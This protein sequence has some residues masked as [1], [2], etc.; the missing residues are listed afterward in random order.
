M[1]AFSVATPFRAAA[2]N[3]DAQTPVMTRKLLL[4]IS[5][6]SAESAAAAERGGANRIELCAD[7]KVGGLTPS[8]ALLR[9]V[10]EKVHLPIYSMIRPRA[11]DFVYSENEFAAMKQSIVEAK[12]CGMGG[13]VLGVLR[14]EQRVDVARTRELVEWAKPLPVTFHRAFD[15]C[16]RK[17]SGVEIADLRQAL[18]DVIQTGAARILT[19]GGAKTALEGGA[20]LRNLVQ[21][22]GERV[23]MLP[24]AGN[25]AENI[26][27]VARRT[28]ATEF[29]SGLS[30]ALPYGSRDFARF[31][32]EVAKLARELAGSRR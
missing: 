24:G 15:E 17:R 19:S 8:R 12:E 30:A 14:K 28:G 20:T 23:V 16:S 9:G 7:L 31:E 6:E 25:S 21:L 29:H 10:R 1:F 32:A 13:V 4:E 27:E 11:G 18:E 2:C 26:A 22:A 5:V 3:S